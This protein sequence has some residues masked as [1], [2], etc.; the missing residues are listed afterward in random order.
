MDNFDEILNK[1]S[2]STIKKLDLN[3]M[4]KIIIFLNQEKCDYIEDLLE[5]YLD[6]FTIEYDEFVNKYQKLNEKYHKEY[7]R[8]ASQDMNLLEEFFFD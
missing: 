2:D 4:N 3:N 1:F 6:L 8:R 7:L 5:D